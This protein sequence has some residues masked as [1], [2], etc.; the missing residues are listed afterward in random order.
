M[1][2]DFF[3]TRAGPVVS[4]GG[5]EVWGAVHEVNSPAVEGNVGLVLGPFL[6]LP[7]ETLCPALLS[8]QTAKLLYMQE[9]TPA[10]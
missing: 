9:A 8:Y 4:A 5:R 6:A 1:V 7:L 10:G 3:F 2:G